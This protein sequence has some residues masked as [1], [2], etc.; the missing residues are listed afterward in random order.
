MEMN[1]CRRCGGPLSNRQNHVYECTKGH[2]IYANHTPAVGVFFVSSDNKNIL[3]NVRGAEPGKGMLGAPGGFMDAKESF[4]TAIARELRE[5]LGLTPDDHTSLTYIT[6][7]HDEYLYGGE[8]I[9]VIT[10]FFWARLEDDKM[11]DIA[12]ANEVAS[13]NWYSLADLD[14]KQ[15]HAH[16]VRTG[17]RELRKVF[18]E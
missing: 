10:V 16:D 1:F 5:E 4:E 17:I 9:P 18:K 14:L 2:I 6:S 3:L 15:V 7:E 12:D 13:V 8:S 11:P